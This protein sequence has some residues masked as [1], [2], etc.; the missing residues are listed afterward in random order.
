MISSNWPLWGPGKT[1]KVQCDA[2][3]MFSPAMFERFVLPALS[4]QCAWLDHAMYHLDGSDCLPH[5]DVLL[6]ID[7]LDAIEWTTDPKV[8]GPCDPHWYP[9][10]RKILAAGKSVQVVGPRLEEIIPLLDA[11]GGR[12]VY[13]LTDLW[14]EREVEELLGKI[15][16]YR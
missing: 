2:C 11:I 15:E 13:L 14:Q 7:E 10:Y 12:G 4:E 5:L 3:A 8:P 16:Q 1:A 6:S 9:L